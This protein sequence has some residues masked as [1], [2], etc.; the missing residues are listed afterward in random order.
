[1]R[2]VCEYD[3][4]NRTAD[5]LVQKNGVLRNRD[6]NPIRFVLNQLLESV[7]KQVCQSSLNQ[8]SDESSQGVHHLVEGQSQ[9][10]FWL[11]IID[12]KS[13][14]VNLPH[15]RLEG[16][17][18]SHEDVYWVKQLVNSPSELTGYTAIAH[19]YVRLGSSPQNLMS[20][21]LSDAG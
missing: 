18:Y 12:A 1:M 10:A 6:D 20:D 7:E 16:D 8:L 3:N 9:V 14:L 21:D 2:I 19:F 5:Y 17:P 15:V 4:L 11:E 13:R